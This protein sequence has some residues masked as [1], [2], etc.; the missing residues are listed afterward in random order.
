[1]KFNKFINTILFL[2]FFQIFLVNST[3]ILTLKSDNFFNY[4]NFEENTNSSNYIVSYEILYNKNI[5][6]NIDFNLELIY[7]DNL[8]KNLCVQNLEINNN[9]IFKKVNCN[10]PKLGSGNYLLKAILIKDK[11][12]V[13]ALENSYTINSIIV[14]EN[15]SNS[16]ISFEEIEGNKTRI[17]IEILEEGKNLIVL[18]KIPKE[19]I[20]NLNEDN[21]NSLIETQLDYEIIES[22]PVIAWNIEN[23]PTKINYT[24]NKK[25]EEKDMK[26]FK[27]EIKD[28]QNFQI[29]K[30][31]IFFLIFIILILIIKPIIFKSKR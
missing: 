13:G 8:K 7:N 29:F 20:E 17:T 6:G 12:I 1:M 16:Q 14:K 3:D 2:L 23:S 22:D 10:I 5:E 4:L 18:T 27:L 25:I 24:I 30:Y 11:K 9:L 19:V 31:L 21:K 15:N 26:N 28:T